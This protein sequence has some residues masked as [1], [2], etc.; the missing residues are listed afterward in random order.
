MKILISDSL[1]EEGIEY[2]RN[3]PGFEVANQPGLSPQDLLE[4][5]RDA[6]A[7]IVR[8]KTKAT[9]EVIEAGPKLRVIGRAG[10]GVDN[11]DLQAA[12]RRGIVV[13]NTPGG[14]SVSAAE[15]AFALML[16]LARKIPF[17][18]ASLRAG[19]WNKSAFVGLELQGKTLGVLG[20]G[21]IGSVLAR[22]ALDFQMRVVAYDPFVSEKYVEDMGA[23]ILPLDEVLRRSD[24][25]S[26]HL[27]SNEKTIGLICRKTIDLMKKGAGLINTARGRL[28]V[29]DDL[30][31][32]LEEGKLMGAA[33]DVFE[34]EPQI[35][36]RLRA[37]DRVVLTP[38][39]AGST[40]EAQAKVGYDIAVQ[41][42]DYLQH[43]VIMNAVNFPS[44][45]P[46]EMSEIQPY[47]QLGEKLG[48]FIAQ[49]SQLRLNEIGIRYYGELNRLNFKPISNYIMKGILKSF[50][51]EEVNEVNAMDYAKERGISVVETTSSRPRSYTNLIS[52]QLRSES[53]TEWVEGA[54][55]R[56]GSPRLVSIDGIPIETELGKT[57]LFIRNDDTPGVIGHVGTILGDSHINI[58]SFVLGRGGDRP[59]A[60][61][62]VNTDSAIP[63]GV[64]EQ[65]R[66]IP[67]V[68]FAQ[69]IQL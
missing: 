6:E 48:S 33:L 34:N 51:S 65:I 4:A 42:S 61:G 29:E 12:T 24:F 66:A 5:I 40:V 54:I 19:N 31:D 28:I 63:E 59:Y 39:I 9:R 18:D 20:L 56:R 62:V 14:N 58:A 35:H 32:A 50:L 16:A 1:S 3:Q 27:P 21:K 49:F 10:A 26:L 43:E 17:A 55:L 37:S 46:K 11:I 7:L 47:A 2:L 45:T 22:R 69:V 15:H 41:I 25:I 8:S 53:E 30:A 52:I 44:I 38:H 67:A 57:M 68:K 60:I 36:P 13:M 23:E 64:L